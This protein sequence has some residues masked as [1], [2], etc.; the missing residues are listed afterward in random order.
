MTPS[1]LLAVL[2]A[3]AT[4]AVLL[5][6]CARDPRP[7]EP[8]PP[9]NTEA[10]TLEVDGVTREYHVHVPTELSDDPAL[11]VMLHGGVGSA[12]QAE[13]AYG[14]NAVADT[15]G[16]VVA[17][18]DGTSRT[19][20][21]GD[22]C[23]GAEREEVDDVAFLTALVAD[24]QDEFGVAADRTFGTGMSNGAMMTYRLACETGM[25]AAIAPVAGTIVSVCDDPAPTSVL[26]IH[27]L[28]DGSV[29]MD[30]EPV[31][32]IGDVDGM[33]IAEV[34]ALWRAAGGC[35]EPVTTEAPP[36][37]TSTST[38]DGG[39]TVTLITVADAGHQW[40]SSVAREG[41]TDQPSDA[42]DA[43]AVIWEFF[44]AV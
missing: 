31:D 21:A 37:T 40:P 29:R 8:T 22:C 32:G 15:E 5:T 43:T 7:H 26:H 11:V 33:P 18:P 28:D 12:A 2:L 1:R 44:A 13:R 10:R 35:G 19:W 20:N 16:F 36:V 38:C 34:N 14:W 27:G 3:T 30:G 23:G 17:Y 9:S 4:A 39:R 25:F 42:L 24:L 41:A 6:G